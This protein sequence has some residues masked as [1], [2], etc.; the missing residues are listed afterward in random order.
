[1]KIKVL[2]SGSKGNCTYIETE[3]LKILIDM[4][5]TYQYL[6]NELNALNISPNN[7]DFILITHTHNDHIKGLQSLVRKTNIKV[8]ITNGMKDD[9]LKKIPIENI[10]IISDETI[11]EDTK[12][13]L[14]HT[15]HDVESVGYI[16]ENNHKSFVYITDTGYINK[17]Y[18]PTLSNK[19]LY[20]IE[21]NHDE[22]MLMDGPYP[23]ILK[24]RVISDKGHLSNHTTGKLLSEIIGNNT[25][26]VVLAHISEKNNTEELAYKTVKDILDSKNINIDI[27]LAKQYESLEVIEV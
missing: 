26:K 4:G 24:Q 25:R 18:I 14:I 13:S 8:L 11:I 19:E 22:K 5:I 10:Q 17:K 23:Y 12:I 3:K 2:A 15:S 1:M 21:S 9:L 16:V 20:I 6:V 7:L 27:E